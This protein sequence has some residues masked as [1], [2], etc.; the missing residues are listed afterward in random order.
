MP[1]HPAKPLLHPRVEERSRQRACNCLGVSPVLAS[2]PAY[3]RRTDVHLDRRRHRALRRAAVHLQPRIATV[4]YLATHLEKPIL[5]EGPAG[6]GKT[7]L[8]KVVAAARSTQAD[9]PAVLRGPRRG[10]G[11]VR[12]GVRQ[13]APLHADPQGQDQRGARRAPLA[14][15]GRRPHRQR[16]RR[17][18][19]RP[20]HPAAA[21]AALDH[22]RPALRAADRRDRQVRHASSRPSCSRCS[23]TSRS[24][25][26][27]SARCAAKHIPLVLLTS[28]NAREM[29]DAL[30]RRCLH[31][32]I[33]FPGASRSC[34]IVR[35][36]V[37]GIVRRWPREVV[38]GRA[39]HPQARSEEVAEHQR[40]AR[41]G[42]DADP[43]QRRAARRGAG[44]RHAQRPSSS[45]RAT[46]ARRR[47]SSRSTC[48][49]QRAKAQ[50]AATR[51]ATTRTCCTERRR[52]PGAPMDAKIVE[53]TALLRANGLRVSM[54]EHLDAF[55]AVDG[56]ASATASRSRT[57]CAPRWSSAPSTC[58]STT[59]SST[60][61]SPASARPSSERRRRRDGAL[62]M[63]DAGVPA[64][65]GR[66][67]RAARRTS[68]STSRSWP[69]A[70]LQNDTGRLE[71]MLR[72]AARAGQ[73][74]ETSS[75]RYQEGRFSH[76]TAQSLGLGGLARSSSDSRS[77][78][79]A[80][81][82][83]SCAEQ[84]E[85]FIDQR[86]HDLRDMIRR[87]CASSSRS[88]TMTPRE[89]S[90]CSAGREELLLSLRGRDAPHARGGHQAGAAAQERR[91]DPPQ[92]RQARQVRRQATRCA[93]TCSTAASR[94][95]SSF[96]RRVRTSRR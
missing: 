2:P 69:Q 23:A 22:L 81:C 21:A 1:T 7:E 20:L 5:V 34:E 90:A 25:C 77:S 58:R 4:V 91:A 28:N 57:R 39:A 92:A 19:L 13:A 66:A 30:K 42:Q 55:R 94:S 49:L 44:Q 32:Y 71:Q 45:T 61:T 60:C 53:F 24:A 68:T 79:R 10:Q 56:S 35:L 36:K 9:P 14:A 31:L 37:P 3:D 72:D 86:L 33:D 11:A 52:R 59:S 50:A 43:A 15:R 87:T 8:A 80:T 48:E 62:Q 12:V 76:S 84:L 6:V 26:P 18:L 29:S 38:G 16:G 64:A 51:R 82:R 40:D 85:Q 46:S 74:A 78:S 93:R 89:R 67:G 73:R 65:P 27:S 96:D 75:A 88:A 70:L 54:A 95:A 17:L 47:T 83:P 63:T 41:L